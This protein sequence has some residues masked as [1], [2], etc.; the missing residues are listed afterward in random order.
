MPRSFLR[1]L[2]LLAMAGM[3][4][5]PIAALVTK[6][7]LAERAVA[8]FDETADEIDVAAIFE[9]MELKSRSSAFRG[10]ELLLWYGGGTLDLREATLDPDGAQLGVRSIFGGMELVVPATWPVQVHSRGIFGGVG[11]DSE[12]PKGVTG[13]RLVIDALSAFGGIHVTSHPSGVP[14]VGPALDAPEPP[15]G[16][17]AEPEAG[18]TPAPAGRGA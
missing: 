8:A 18:E 13:P 3:V 15:T 9:G 11:D 1:L 7:R 17:T 6:R 5:P 14:E 10:G 12:G 4:I 2:G 16:P